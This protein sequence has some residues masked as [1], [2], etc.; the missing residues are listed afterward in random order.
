MRW[1]PVIVLSLW[2][3]TSVASAPAGKPTDSAVDSGSESEGSSAGSEAA[4]AVPSL[5]VNAA[6]AH[7]VVAAPLRK[8][9]Q[10]LKGVVAAAHRHS[11]RAVKRRVSVWD[12]EEETV[13]VLP[14]KGPPDALLAEVAQGSGPSPKAARRSRYDFPPELRA[15]KADRPRF[16]KMAIPER[17]A[18][19]VRTHTVA[20]EYSWACSFVGDS[21]RIQDGSVSG[22]WAR[23][24]EVMA[25]SRSLM[26][27]EA[28]REM[29]ETDLR[30]R[31]RLAEDKAERKRAQLRET[32]LRRAVHQLDVTEEVA[33]QMWL[34]A[35]AALKQNHYQWIEEDLEELEEL[36]RDAEVWRLKL[37]DD[38]PSFAP[39][40]PDHDDEPDSEDYAGAPPSAAVSAGLALVAVAHSRRG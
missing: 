27:E 22:S 1:G 6:P 40:P 17:L 9:S 11:D 28:N 24:V 10:S 8:R 7:D 21:R 37:P 26:M 35:L 29:R 15:A 20:Q 25:G 4:A 30:V 14:K 19:K 12:S 18:P 31:R 23:L 38:E 32:F 2:L 16:V 34:P 36:I 13:P 39:G 3:L 5:E 33:E